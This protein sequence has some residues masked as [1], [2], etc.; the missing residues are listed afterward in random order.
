MSTFEKFDPLYTVTE[1]GA[2]YLDEEELMEEYKQNWEVV[3]EFLKDPEY[4]HD[5]KDIKNRISRITLY[6]EYMSTCYLDNE[7]E[8]EEEEDYEEA[9]ARFEAWKDFYYDRN[10]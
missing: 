3:A 4:P 10:M 1:C 6:L 5:K 2:K 8:E 9:Q 7:E